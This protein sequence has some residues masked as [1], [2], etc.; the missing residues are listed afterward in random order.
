MSVPIVEGLTD[1]EG[2]TTYIK[3]N[4]QT[5]QIEYLSELG[6]LGV[7]TTSSIGDGIIDYHGPLNFKIEGWQPELTGGTQVGA[8]AVEVGTTA[9]GYEVVTGAGTVGAVSLIEMLGGILAGLGIGIASYELNKDFWIDVSNNLFLNMPG[10]VPIRY[11]NIEDMSIMALFSDGKTYIDYNLIQ[12]VNDYLIQIG[13]YTQG[14]TTV[15]IDVPTEPGNYSFDSAEVTPA[16]VQ[17]TFGELLNHLNLNAI[18]RV[19]LTK[20]VNY[21][22]ADIPASAYSASTNYMAVVTFVPQISPEDPNVWAQAGIEVYFYNDEL[23]LERTLSASDIQGTYANVPNSGH[24]SI[25]G[26]RGYCTYYGGHEI[27]HQVDK[28]ISTES[29][30]VHIGFYPPQNILCSFNNNIIISPVIPEFTDLEPR[31]ISTTPGAIPQ[32]MTQWWTQKKTLRQV[33]TT[34][35]SETAVHMLP[36]TVPKTSPK[37]QPVTTPQLDIQTGTTPDTNTKPIADMPVKVFPSIEIPVVIPTPTPKPTPPTPVIPSIGG[38]ANALFT[39]YNPS[40]ANLNSL[41]SVLWSSNIIQQ[42]VQM[43]TNNPLD[44]IISLHILYAT[45]T[46]GANKEIKLGYVATGVSCPEVTNQYVNVSCGTV[47]VPEIYGDVRDYADT[48]V[49]IYLPMIG[50]R[51]LKTEDVIS[52]VVSV[53]YRVDVFTGTVLATITI[54]KP[55]VAQVLYTFEGNCA[56]NLPLTGAD[57]SRQL[58]TAVGTIGA[59]ATGNPLMGMASA[60][61]IAGGG[62]RATIQRSGNFSGNAGAMG[63][64]KPYLIIA[65]NIPYDAAAYETQ[66]GY[67]ANLTVMLGTCHGYV[68]A[69]EVHADS[70]SNAT[71]KEKREIENQLKQGVI[72]H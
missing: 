53:D 6:D 21:A 66:Y 52:S 8:T 37:T 49:S 23:P 34:T 31:T 62:A 12:E 68:K 2:F 50:I 42:I 45:P 33:D 46:T 58:A 13:A 43:F 27:S 22:V 9:T 64:K 56:V 36:V 40:K 3:L 1:L 57:K 63:C 17:A 55:N 4:S 72:I 54:S 11:D 24:R 61:A 65:T 28:P 26:A 51:Q 47:R 35:G 29:Y 25:Y 19:M 38:D 18:Q 48:D 10:Y 20:A 59:V 60:T 15:V 7:E 44:A 16:N 5:Q 67:P 14:Q 71:E 70:I 39:V 41:G 69:K 32:E 30:S